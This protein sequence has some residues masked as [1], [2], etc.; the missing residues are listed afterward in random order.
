MQQVVRHAVAAPPRG[1]AM[2]AT[3]AVAVDVAV[4]I[5]VNL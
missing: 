2:D 4:A 5:A 1:R 3:V